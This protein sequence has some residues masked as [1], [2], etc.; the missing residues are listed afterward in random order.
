[1][2]VE[3]K[4]RTTTPR[5]GM[6]GRSA[7]APAARPAPRG[8]RYS[9]PVVLLRS[10]LFETGRIGSM[11]FFAITGQLLWPFSFETRYRYM[12]LWGKFTLWWLRLTC[13]IRYEVHGLEHVDMSRPGLIFARHESAWETIALQSIF[14]PQ[15]YVLKQELLRIPFFGWGMALLHP[16]ALDRKAGRKALQKLVSEGLKRLE[17]GLWV[18]IFPEGTRMPPGV[19]GEIKIGGPMLAAQADVPSHLVAHNAGEVWP[20][21]SFL[22]YPGRIRV[23]IS[24]PFHFHGQKPKAIS[25][26]MQRWFAEHLL[27]RPQGGQAGMN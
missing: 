23:E 24:A 18:V 13:G 10:T 21:N 26:Q 19:L 7:P 27:S 8:W 5:S 14:P 25:E 20:K 17:A 9:L 1:M 4:P 22:K 12:T 6:A 3:Q 15:V 11:I 2:A 16:I